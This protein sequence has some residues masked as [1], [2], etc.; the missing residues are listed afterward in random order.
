MADQPR[1]HGIEHA[2]EQEAAAAG[3][4]DQ[5]LL[6]VGGAA[7]RQR[8][9]HGALDLQACDAGRHW[10]GRHLGNKAAVGGEIGEVA[11]ATQKQCLR[12]GLP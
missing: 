3:D 8:L 10:R 2:A 11:A 5:F 6:E 9:E 1:G 12:Q 7:R 4:D